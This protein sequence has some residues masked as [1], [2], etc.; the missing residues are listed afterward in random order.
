MSAGGGS[1]CRLCPFLYPG[2][3]IVNETVP[4]EARAWMHNPAPFA[5]GFSSLV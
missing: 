2:A 5:A 4:S 3:G 1:D